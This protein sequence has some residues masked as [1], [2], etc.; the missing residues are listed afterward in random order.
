MINNTSDKFKDFA[1][2][3]YSDYTN[4]S[5][6][7]TKG[8]SY[9]LS[10]TPGLSWSGILP[11]AFCR[12]W[13]D[14]N[15]NNTFEANELVLEKTNVNPMTANVLIP[16]TAA[17]GNVRM[18][19]A[20]KWGNYPT[21]CETFE[22]GEVEDYTVNIIP[23]K[24]PTVTTQ[25]ITLNVNATPSV[26]L[27]WTAG[28]FTIS[29]KNNL[30]K[31]LNNVKIEFPFP[32]KINNGGGVVPSV[33]TWEEYCVGN[34]KCY[35]WTIPTFNA[36]ATAT[37]EVPIFVADAVEPIVATARLVNDS[38]KISASF[39]IN[40][41]PVKNALSRRNPTQFIPIVLESIE[42][43]LTD[44]DVFVN[45]ESIIEQAVRFDFY[46]VLGKP[47]KSEYRKI[48]VGNNRL[49]F[50][51]FD[52]EDGVYFIQT[53]EGIGRDAPLKFVKF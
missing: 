11:T 41:A 4:F 6:T 33:G 43:N 19:V 31:P 27:Q 20:I 48:Q 18:R 51:F 30:N 9:P 35:V 24:L 28:N 15:N 14:F 21:A 16:I 10:I 17:T 32:A 46:N 26:Y 44:G 13:I 5:I 45:I 1:T 49:Y 52:L 37:L 50:D 34:V 40:P 7:V 22:K 25:N 12:V 3:G 42:P 8:Q 29:A 36:N 23:S 47:V 53:E 39:T 2:L 38:S